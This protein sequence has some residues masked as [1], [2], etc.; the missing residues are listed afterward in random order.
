MVQIGIIEWKNV[1]W[2][3]TLISKELP[4]YPRLPNIDSGLG[5]FLKTEYN[6]PER[7]Q[8]DIRSKV[9]DGQQYMKESF[10]MR[11]CEATSFEIG[12]LVFVM[13]A[14]EHTGVP[15][16]SQPRYRGPM[17]VTVEEIHTQ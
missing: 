9:V 1:I 10:D 8:D 16:K 3:S 4:E 15:T 2:P 13:R 11:A 6:R 14:M 5:E 17:V 7:L 12:D